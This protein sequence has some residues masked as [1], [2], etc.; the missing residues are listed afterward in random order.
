MSNK[1]ARGE[2]KRNQGKNERYTMAECLEKRDVDQNF[3]KC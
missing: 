2:D 1:A 3:G